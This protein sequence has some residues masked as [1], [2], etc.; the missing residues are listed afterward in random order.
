MGNKQEDELTP[1]QKVDD[2]DL[3]VKNGCC[4]ESGYLK[5]D[6]NE[7]ILFYFS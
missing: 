3:R 4:I 7:V 6:D 5:L 1:T 2:N